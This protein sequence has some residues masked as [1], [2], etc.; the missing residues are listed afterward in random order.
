[1]AEVYGAVTGPGF[2]ETFSTFGAGPGIGTGPESASLLKRMLHHAK[3]PV[4]LDADAL[5]L[6]AADPQLLELVPGDSILTPHPGEFRRLAGDW[7]NDFE[8]LDLQLSF[9]DKHRVFL[10]LKGKNTTVATPD[11]HLWFNTTGNSGM[12]KG[13]SGDVLTGLLSGL[14]AS[15]YPPRDTC[16]LGTWLH[17]KAGDLLAAKC[18]PEA[19]KAGDLTGMLGEAWKCVAGSG[20]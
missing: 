16:I 6:L 8:K 1:M 2:W 13:G 7:R 19:M 5:N 17:G 10:L 14:L 11:G 15:G 20:A 9:A 3:V 4:V 12:A 18:T